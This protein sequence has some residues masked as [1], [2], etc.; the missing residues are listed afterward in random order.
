M[1]NTV[2]QQRRWRGYAQRESAHEPVLRREGI[3]LPLPST[4]DK[5]GRDTLM[6]ELLAKRI[7]YGEDASGHPLEYPGWMVS[8]KCR[9]LRRVIP[10]VKSDR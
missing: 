10:L 3:P 1:R 2:R 8:D 7:R 4:R 6:R 9:Q 5:L